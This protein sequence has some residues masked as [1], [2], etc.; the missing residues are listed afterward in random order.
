MSPAPADP[1]SL[2]FIDDTRPPTPTT[3]PADPRPCLL[4]VDDTPANIDVLVGVLRSDYELKVA[5]RGAKALQICASGQPVDLILLD[6][7]MP[8]MDG[9]EVCRRLRAAP[10]TR[11]IP[12]IFITA[13]TEIDDVVQGFAL[14]AN[15]YVSKPFRPP[16]LLARVRTHLTLRDQ[17]REIARKNAELTEMIHILCH[18]VA[19]QFAVASLSLQLIEAF[20]ETGVSRALPRIASAVKNGIALTALV[21]EMRRAEVKSLAIGPVPLRAAFEEA[22]QIVEDRAREKN[23]AIRVDLPDVGILAERCSL[24]NSVFGNLLTNAVKFSRPGSSVEIEARAEDGFL[25]LRVRDHGIGIPVTILAHLFEVTKTVSRPGTAGEKGTG[26]GMPLVRKF[27]ELY[28]GD[29]RV[30]S[31]DETAHPGDSGTEVSLRFRLAG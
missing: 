12:V 3:M 16:E 15:D 25:T 17:R 30:E 31:R 1:R 18:D 13:K 10:E 4:L 23:V 11:D 19:N 29:L 27:V 6:I 28:G 5:N 21:R 26:F 14:G 9:Y 8:E 24:V 20:P 7:M 22:A 2:L